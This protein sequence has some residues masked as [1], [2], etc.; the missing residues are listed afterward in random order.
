MVYMMDPSFVRI[1]RGL[2]KKSIVKF[3]PKKRKA[4]GLVKIRDL[5]TVFHTADSWHPA[6]RTCYNIRLHAIFQ[7]NSNYIK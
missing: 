7:M 2:L 1:L 3:R 6:I 5:K 4:F